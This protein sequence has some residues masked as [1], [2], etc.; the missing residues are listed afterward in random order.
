MA[1]EFFDLLLMKNLET[2]KFKDKIKEFPD[3]I[4]DKEY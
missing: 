1:K 2:L 3:K 4:A